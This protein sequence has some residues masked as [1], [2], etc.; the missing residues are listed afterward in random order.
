VNVPHPLVHAWCQTDHA[1]GAGRVVPSEAGAKLFRRT[2]LS[3]FRGAIRHWAEQRGM[4]LDSIEIAASLDEGSDQ[5]AGSSGCREPNVVAIE[6]VGKQAMNIRLAI[7]FGL[8]IFRGHFST[9]PIVPG[10]QLA[11]WAALLATRHATWRHGLRAAQVL[12]FRRIVQPGFE[13]ELGLQWNEAATRLEFRYQRAAI[14][15]AQGIIVAP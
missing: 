5:G 13:Y 2:G 9:V 12:K 4:A 7:P 1:P 14:M 15:H 6:P 11:G 3:G 8:P 10:A